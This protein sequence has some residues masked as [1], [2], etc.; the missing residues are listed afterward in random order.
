MKAV[1]R[2]MYT[3]TEEINSKYI[4]TVNGSGM[5]VT[6]GTCHRGAVSPELFSL[7]PGGA[8]PP[9][10]LVLGAKERQQTK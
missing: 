3:M 6:C 8:T 2:L 4:A 10:E 7:Q 5:P 1:A 9:V